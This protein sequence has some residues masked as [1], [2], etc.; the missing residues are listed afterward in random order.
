MHIRYIISRS[1]LIGVA[2]VAGLAGLNVV[3]AQQSQQIKQAGVTVAPAR[4]IFDLAK[5]AKSHEDVVS[6]RNNLSVAMAFDASLRAVQQAS[7]GSLVPSDIADTA[8]ASMLEVSPSEFTLSP[9]QSINIKL[10]FNDISKLGPG[11]HYVSLLIRERSTSSRQITVAQAVSVM[12]FV[13]KQDGATREVSVS[14]VVTDASLIRPPK[15]ITAS[16]GSLGNTALVPRGTVRVYDPAGRL[17]GTGLINEGSATVLPTREIRLRSYVSS[18]GSLW[19]P[20][21]YKAELTYRYEGSDD[22][23]VVTASS[24]VMPPLFL[25]LAAGALIILAGVGR[26]V[27]W[28]WPAVRLR[29]K[30][31]PHMQVHTPQAQ[32]KKAMDIVVRRKH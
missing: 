7:N 9:G 20:G 29:M 12:I 19:M 1:L 28:I 24:W 26:F 2:I 11:G 21:R 32:P 31:R 15:S 6:V 22:Q 23:H 10:R 16:F 3:N 30:G 14:N 8:M 13:T 25:A 4:L 5:G 18:Q 27:W 17:A